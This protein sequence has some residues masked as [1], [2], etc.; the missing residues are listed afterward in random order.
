L[1]R[2]IQK[3]MDQ[4]SESEKV[5]QRNKYN[6]IIEILLTAGYFRVRINTL[7]EFDKVVGGLCWCITSSGELVDV[8]ILFQ[9]NST[10]GQK[11]SLAEAVVK[12]LRKMGCPCPLQPHQIQGGVGGSD[13]PALHQAIVWLIKKYFERRGEREQQLRAYSTF[14]FSK[15]YQLPNE[16]NDGKVSINLTKILNRNKAVRLYKRKDFSG[17]SIE[18]KVRACLIEFG[19]TFSRL[20]GN[21][22][23]EQQ[24]NASSSGNNVTNINLSGLTTTPFSTTNA[25]TTDNTISKQVNS[26]NTNAAVV[27]SKSMSIIRQIGGGT[28]LKNN[29]KNISLQDGSKSGN[30]NEGTTTV[31]EGGEDEKDRLK[32]HLVAMA[33]SADV[34]LAGLSKIDTTELSGF[35]KQLAKVFFFFKVYIFKILIIY[36][37]DCICVS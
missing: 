30:T 10:I 27:A 26:N 20:G 23:T 37:N 25:S 8:D 13:Y 7:S 4:T 29:K 18:T 17:E 33:D 6:E 1:K 12:A 21:E 34:T 22:T 11:I 24:L 28:T 16:A 3:I 5:Y 14:Q 35:E 15:N 9:E 19:E 32:V 36:L 2:K 31:A